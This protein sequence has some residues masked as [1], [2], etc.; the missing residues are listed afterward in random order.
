MTFESEL[1]RELARQGVDAR[2]SRRIVAELDDHLTCDPEA[3][4]GSPALIAERFAVE[5]RLSQTRR[6]TFGG[7]AALAVTGSLIIATSLGITAAGGWPDFGGP[8]SYFVSLGGL[9]LIL[10]GQSHSSPACWRCGS[11][12]AGTSRLRSLSGACVSR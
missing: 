3:N 1:R 6:A 7:F 5:L 4:L 10:G 2:R 9:A 11:S 12:V 8:R